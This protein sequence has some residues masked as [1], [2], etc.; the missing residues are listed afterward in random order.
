LAPST[1]EAAKKNVDDY[2]A[3]RSEDLDSLPEFGYVKY[4]TGT[5][6]C[7]AFASFGRFYIE[8][9]MF[10]YVTGDAALADAREFLAIYKQ[11]IAPNDDNEVSVV[12]AL[13]GSGLRKPAAD[14]KLH[15]F[16]PETSMK[17]Q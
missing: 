16:Q 15:A 11:K 5:T 3:H 7:V 6:S 2:T 13:S 12:S 17:N 4:Q 10:G 1:Y 8:I 14:N 9:T